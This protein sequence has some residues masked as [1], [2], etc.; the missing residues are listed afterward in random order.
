[1]TRMT[2]RFG[3]PGP[4]DIVLNPEKWQDLANILESRGQRPLDGKVGTINFSK[5]QIAMGGKMVNI[6]ADRFC[7]TTDAYA[8]SLKNWKFRSYGPML[9]VLKGDG[10]EML[11]LATADTYEHRL[12]SFPVLSTNAPSYSG[13]CTV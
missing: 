13:R 11:R 12:V 10:L 5:I 6:W 7:P 8:L 9:D 1:V 3:G 4:S 2:G